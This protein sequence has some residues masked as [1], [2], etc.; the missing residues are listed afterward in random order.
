MK[1]E[2]LAFINDPGQL[3][4]MYRSNKTL[5]KKEF[6]LIYPQVAG[7]QVADTWNERLNY[8]FDSLSFGNF[9]EVAIIIGLALLAGFIAKIPSI[10]SLDEEVFYPRNIG[11]VIFPILA[12]YFAWKNNLSK[13]KIGVIA[14]VMFTG[15]IY[16][17]LLP[18]PETD[19]LI[20]S[21]IHLILLLWAVTGFSFVGSFKRE[22]EKRLGYLKFNGD[23]VVMTTLIVIAGG[24]MSGITIGLFELIG[25]KI[26]EFYFNYIG[27]IG[28]AVSPIVATYLIR[29]NPQLV[30]KVSPVIAKIFSPLVLIML[31]VFLGAMAFSGK[32]PYNDR[33]FLIIFN[34]LLVGVMAIIFFSV[35]E[36]S[37]GEKGRIELWILLL[38]STVTI[39]VNSIA[40]SAILFRIS[41]WGLSPNRAAVLGA[42]VLIL[43]NLIMVTA[44][45]YKVIRER[46]SAS[47]VGVVIAKYLPVYV[48]WTAIVTFTFPF[49]F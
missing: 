7:N 24:I 46:T 1:E 19:V 31:L 15:L 36:S 27:I 10:F 44:Q 30:G 5:F 18:K 16:I 21:C 2:I 22:G 23:L 37:S 12:G 9:K 29:T 20:L 38:L 45:L 47:E 14:G 25:F 32:D 13:A 39:I 17:N 40:L 48:I 28:L 34:A 35:A 3:E 49:I 8:E 33:E 42:N 4:K 43:I 6:S 11:F 26:E 41:E